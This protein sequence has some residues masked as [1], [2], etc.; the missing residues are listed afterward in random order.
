MW[1]YKLNVEKSLYPGAPSNGLQLTWKYIRNF[2][3]LFYFEFF[4][5]TEHTCATKRETKK[6]IKNKTRS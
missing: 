3:I 4:S 2:F 5:R 1:S 6:R